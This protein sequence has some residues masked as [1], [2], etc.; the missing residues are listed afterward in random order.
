MFGGFSPSLRD[1]YKMGP[2]AIAGASTSWVRWI[3]EALFINEAREYPM[4]EDLQNIL[5][6]LHY[7]MDYMS[8]DILMVLLIALLSRVTAFLLLHFLDRDKQK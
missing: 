4:T 2:V 1:I 8:L 3:Q 7:N 6:R 5:D